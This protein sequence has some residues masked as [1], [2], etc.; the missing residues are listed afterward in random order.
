M[1]QKL[2]DKPNKVIRE[3]ASVLVM[4]DGERGPEVFMLQRPGRGVFPDLHVFPGGKVDAD[5]SQLG[6]RLAPPQSLNHPPRKFKAAALREC[7]EECGVLYAQTP[8]GPLDAREMQEFRADLLNDRVSFKKDFER[9]SLQFQDD[10]VLYFSHWITPEF[11]PARFDTRF[12]I[13][14]VPP[15][16]EARNY[17]GETIAGSWQTPEQALRRYA[18]KEWQM[19]MPTLTTL[20]MIAGYA[21]VDALMAIVAQ[22]LH[23]IPV[24]PA[25]H[26]QGMQRYK[27]IWCSF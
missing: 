12:F 6:E 4:R 13:A 24:T 10:H 9:L 8:T 1:N 14:H 23:R 22:G 21:T 7:F 25:L 15:E 2:I 17:A 11:A 20:R 3:A 19:I 27:G 16:Q 18:L 26:K 5:D